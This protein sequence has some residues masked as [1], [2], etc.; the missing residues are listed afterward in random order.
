MGET[1]DAQVFDARQKLF[2]LESEKGDMLAGKISKCSPG[3][4]G[5]TKNI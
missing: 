5:R 1:V 4:E 2:M 3:G